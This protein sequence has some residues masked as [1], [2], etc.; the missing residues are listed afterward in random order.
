MTKR[1]PKKELLSESDETSEDSSSWSVLRPFS[2]RWLV[3]RFPH[4]LRMD[5]GLLSW[6]ESN[7]Q[8]LV[9]EACVPVNGIPHCVIR[10]PE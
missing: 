5:L 8:V 3:D 4:L 6:P 7:F 10:T 2:A 1:W 9:S